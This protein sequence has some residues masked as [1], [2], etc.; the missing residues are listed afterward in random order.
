MAITPVTQLF[1]V[2][3]NALGS[4]HRSYQK[5]RKASETIQELNRLS[6][7]ELMDIGLTRGDIYSVAHDC[8]SDYSDKINA[9]S[10]PNQNLKGWV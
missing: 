10:G 4:L 7:S 6:N 2:V 8:M 3:F 9:K 1:K 5:A